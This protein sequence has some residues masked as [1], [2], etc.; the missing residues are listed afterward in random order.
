[1]DITGE[2]EPGQ[3]RVHGHLL[4]QIRQ[5]AQI[6]NVAWTEK[7]EHRP[8]IHGQVPL[9]QEVRQQVIEMPDVVSF[10]EVSLLLKNLVA[11][12]VP[13]AGPGLV[14]PAETVAMPQFR[15]LEQIHGRPFQ[16]LSAAAE[17]IVP[18]AQRRYAVVG[19][20]LP[21]RAARLEHAKVVKPQI[22]RQTRLE[23]SLE[24]RTS[25]RGVRPFREA[26]SPPAVVLR[27]RVKLREEERHYLKR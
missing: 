16:Q 24:E 11:A 12:A 6:R 5:L 23:M 8:A 10:T 22:G 18:V 15:V 2:V 26:R 27:Y 20:E 1:M 3:A 17:P 25:R 19:G 9:V 21:L 4:P 14:S 13:D 7:V